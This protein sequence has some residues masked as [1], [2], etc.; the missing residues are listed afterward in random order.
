MMKIPASVRALYEAQ[1]AICRNLKFEIDNTLMVLKSPRWHYESRIKGLESY[2]V[3]IESG[4]VRYPEKLE[5]FFACTIVVPNTSEIDKAIS[6]IEGRFEIKYRRPQSTSETSKAAD[7]FRFDDLRLYVK[8]GN[9]GSR[10][11]VPLDEVLFEVQIKTFL[12]HAW[13]V[14]THDLTYKS[15]NVRWGKDRIAAHL[16]AMIEQAEISIQEAEHLSSS[17]ALSMNDAS[18]NIVADIIKVLNLHWNK[19]DLPDNLR[20]LANIINSI[21]TSMNIKPA[22]L[23]EILT[24]EKLLNAGSLDLN[25]SPYGVI[26]QA[27]ARH[28]RVEFESALDNKTN[29]LKIVLLPEMTLPAG[30]PN[31]TSMASI[32][33]I[34]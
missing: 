1:E 7:V 16:R 9:D 21:I 5:D 18:S 13:S 32:I 27:L 17:S 29:K 23:N 33:H 28:R 10:P 31:I 34:R 19:S 14:A 30:F 20:G 12:Q 8:R 6:L 15:E 11:S 24:K 4:R 22:E 25:V 26:I 2:A 3:K